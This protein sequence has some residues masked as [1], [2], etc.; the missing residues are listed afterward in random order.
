MGHEEFI[1]VHIKAYGYRHKV[2]RA[3]EERVTN[4]V[5]VV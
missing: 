4:F 5:K 2:L 1:E 3:V